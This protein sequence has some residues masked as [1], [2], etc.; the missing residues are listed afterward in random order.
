MTLINEAM[1][2]IDIEGT[3]EDISV[4]PIEI[5]DEIPQSINGDDFKFFYMHP[6]DGTH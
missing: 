2:N 6:T 3:G 4:I 1:I 5:V